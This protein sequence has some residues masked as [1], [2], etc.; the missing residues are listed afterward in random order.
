MTSLAG[1]LRAASRACV[2]LSVLALAAC[3]GS[4]GKVSSP[5]PATLQIAASAS[6]TRA[7]AD[8]VSLTATTTGTSAAVAWSL[9]GPG[10]LSASAG[11]EVSY[12][13][14]L[15]S[16]LGAARSATITA[17][18]GTLSKS[19][20]VTLQ[21][22]P[23]GHWEAVAL[24]KG[25]FYNVKCIAGLFF[26]LE[27]EGMLTSTDAV[28]WTAASIPPGAL[29]V[30][31]AIGDAGYVGVSNS[32]HVYSSV[33]G[34]TWTEGSVTASTDATSLDPAYMQLGT[35]A[36]GQ[37]TYVATG[38][39]GVATSVDGVHWVSRT[40]PKPNGMSIDASEIAFGQGR[41]VAADYA[42]NVTSVDGVNWE[43]LQGVPSFEGV[44]FGN[45]LFVAR[46]ATNS[47]SSVD[48]LAWSQGG[49]V[50]AA[51]DSPS[52]G[53]LAF[54]NG[55]F[56][57]FSNVG[58]VAS[59]DGS[60]W[61]LVYTLEGPYSDTSFNVVTG[62]AASADETVV[63][64]WNGLFAEGADDAWQYVAIGSG[65]MM[66]PVDCMNGT[67]VSLSSDGDVLV[68]TD[69]RTWSKVTISPHA[70]LGAITHGNGSFVVGAVG[71][72]WASA[73]ARTWT[74]S[75]LGTTSTING[76]AFG[77]GRFVAVGS[78][79]AVFTSTDG[80]SW[81]AVPAGIPLQG[82]YPTLPVIAYGAGKFVTM[83]NG[84]AVYSSA[85][86]VTWAAGAAGAPVG[87][88]VF[89]ETVGFV[90]VGRD[91]SVW[92]SADGGAW[93]PSTA[94]GTDSGANP[95]INAVAYGDSQF[96]AVGGGGAILVSEDAIHWS[97]RSLDMQAAYVGV[98]F[99]GDA[100]VAVGSSGAIA[101]SSE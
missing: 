75:A 73:D 87:S 40:G 28:H 22:A 96:V 45:G 100:F 51:G 90:A 2:V 101:L 79:N 52:W 99:T 62:V 77:S 74:H 66:G 68:T 29:I 7:G 44:A 11:A 50:T 92:R 17:T 34:T 4:G 39:Q 19:L 57:A 18:V 53:R 86:G 70:P 93:S 12:V 33:D 56:Y 88:L 65:A 20:Q 63:V 54:G 5:P 38:I 48:G 72:T 3:G 98:G 94:F 81:T 78:G 95:G 55:S 32:N 8:P 25:N 16:Q 67:C 41:F 80:A 23:G 10:T 69:A 9:S 6:G 71:E 97:V 49:S 15:P 43:V 47:W 27:G 26:A 24:P 60:Q 1:C 91:G 83:D 35:V 37:G 89:G 42:G 30:D 82:P 85:D 64:G 76:I 31:V 61:D 21:A 59:A 84:G 46:D 13:P 36:F 58:V 14:P